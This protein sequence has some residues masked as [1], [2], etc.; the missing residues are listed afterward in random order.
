MYTRPP[1]TLYGVEP[2]P[3]L[4]IVSPI[5]LSGLQ[6]PS[7]ACGSPHSFTPE[8]R[9]DTPGGKC[10]WMPCSACSPSSRDI[11]VVNGVNAPAC[12]FRLPVV[13]VGVNGSGPSH[14]CLDPSGPVAISNGGELVSLAG[15]PDHGEIDAFAL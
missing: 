8:S 9:P 14:V 12:R 7:S 13:S 10:S 15:F 4:T 3:T 11:V 2:T 5:K 6:V 1:L